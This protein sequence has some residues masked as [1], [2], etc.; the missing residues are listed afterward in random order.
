MKFKYISRLVDG[1]QTSA[2]VY[3][4]YKIYQSVSNTNHR[5]IFE[6]LSGDNPLVQKVAGAAVLGTEGLLITVAVPIFLIVTIDG[7]VGMYKGAHHYFLASMIGRVIE[8]PEIK[9][10]NRKGLENLLK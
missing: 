4:L 9:D 8:N 7:I 6:V 3:L 1:I 2:G 5:E 10:F